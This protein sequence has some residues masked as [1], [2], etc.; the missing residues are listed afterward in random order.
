MS[1]Y[2]CHGSF[3]LGTACGKCPACVQKKAEILSKLFPRASV[4][5]EF[6]KWIADKPSYYTEEHRQTFIDGWKRARGE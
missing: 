6:D 1:N 5:D 2:Q 4:M 3:M